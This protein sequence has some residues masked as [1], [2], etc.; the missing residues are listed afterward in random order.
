MPDRDYMGIPVD[1]A[2]LLLDGFNCA[3]DG[4]IDPMTHEQREEVRAW[5]AGLHPSLQD[6]LD[7]V[8]P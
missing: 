5:F 2:A 8:K 3:G 1:V 7:G 6:K 4:G